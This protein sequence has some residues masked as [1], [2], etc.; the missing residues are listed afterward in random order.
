MC[1]IV[2]IH[3]PDVADHH[4]SILHPMVACVS[5]RGPDN[6][7]LHTI[8]DDSVSLGHTRLAIIDPSTE[9]NQPMAGQNKSLWITFNGEIY[10]HKQ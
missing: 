5:H 6:L 8:S 9:A 4:L 2:G 1:G 3:S 10:N 7:G